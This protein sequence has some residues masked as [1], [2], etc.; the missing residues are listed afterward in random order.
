MACDHVNKETLLLK[1]V[2]SSVYKVQNRVMSGVN[3][4][5]CIGRRFYEK[6]S[7]CLQTF[8]LSYNYATAQSYKMSGM[9]DEIH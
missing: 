3:F 8:Y 9:I 1:V 4:V 5:R 7:V 6:L 2:L